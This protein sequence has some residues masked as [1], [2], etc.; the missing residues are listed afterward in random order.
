MSKGYKPSDKNRPDVEIRE[1]SSEVGK[2]SSDKTKTSWQFSLERKELC[3]LSVDVGNK[4]SG[5]I[6]G[7]N[8]LITSGKNLLGF[9]PQTTASEIID[10]VNKNG[11]K[12][13][14]NVIS[15]DKK[16]DSIEETDIWVELNLI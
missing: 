16:E 15:V 14:G 3:S 9:A 8:V 4:V 5:L 13:S 1:Q 2:Q 7:N 12:L 6:Q 10:A 11:G